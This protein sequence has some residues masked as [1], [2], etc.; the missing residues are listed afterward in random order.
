MSPTSESARGEPTHPSL[1]H[2][3]PLEV[4]VGR[5][6]VVE[7]SSSNANLIV[8]W[9]CGLG[10]HMLTILRFSMHDCVTFTVMVMFWSPILFI[11][12]KVV[13]LEPH[14]AVVFESDISI[15]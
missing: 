8:S 4:V 10:Q 1:G 12:C 14:Q 3:V 7:F 5:N 11:P 2:R 15:R 13:Q 6:L 9:Y